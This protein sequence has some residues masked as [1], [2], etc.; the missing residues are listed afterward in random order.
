MRDHGNFLIFNETTTDNE[1]VSHERYRDRAHDICRMNKTRRRRRGLCEF[2]SAYDTD[3]I[4]KLPNGMTAV[5]SFALSLSSVVSLHREVPFPRRLFSPS[6]CNVARD[7]ESRKPE[8]SLGGRRFTRLV[9][10]A[11]VA[12]LAS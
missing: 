9:T 6:V 2:Y 8:R 5:P 10:V 11:P 12:F 1:L 3:S 7:T 4:Q